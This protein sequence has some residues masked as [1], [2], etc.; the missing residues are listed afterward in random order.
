MEY[1]EL[2]QRGKMALPQ[3]VIERDRFEIPKAKG[4]LEGN[5]TIISNFLQIAGIFRRSP[6]HLL[7][8]VLRELAVPGEIRKQL[9]IL[10]S[11]LPAVRLN[12]KLRQYAEEFV[13]CSKCGKPD[14][15]LKK[16]G[17]FLIKVCSVCGAR[18]PVK[19]K[20]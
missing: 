18:Q 17:E 12:D 16:E 20:I 13:L 5:K 1:L 6:E 9:L 14:T 2:L 11:K 3:S 10:G 4:H 8:Y 7:K 15:D 19:S